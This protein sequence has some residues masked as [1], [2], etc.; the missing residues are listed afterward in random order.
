MLF[1]NQNPPNTLCRLVS[2]GV[3]RLVYELSLEPCGKPSK[4]TKKRNNKRLVQGL[5]FERNSK[6]PVTPEGPNAELEL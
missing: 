5:G 1:F 2:E 4:N 6:T 3:Y